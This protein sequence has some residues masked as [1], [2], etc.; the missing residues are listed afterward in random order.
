MFKKILTHLLA[1]FVGAG[2]FGGITIGAAIP[3]MN[4]YGVVY[5]VITWPIT[6]YCVANNCDPFPGGATGEFVKK[7]I[8]DKKD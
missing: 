3:A 5:Y 8:F 7:L 1:M 4:I 2:L 6:I